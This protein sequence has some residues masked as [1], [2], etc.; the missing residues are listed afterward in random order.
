MNELDIDKIAQKVV[1]IIKKPKAG[2]GA[3][4]AYFQ[5][6]TSLTTID[7]TYQMYG[8]VGG[9]GTEEGRFT[10]SVLATYLFNSPVLNSP[11]TNNW[12]RAQQLSVYSTKPPSG[13]S[14]LY[15]VQSGSTYTFTG[16][17]ND[18]SVVSSLFNNITANG[19]INGSVGAPIAS[20]STINLDAATG[21]VVHITGTTNINNVTLAAGSSRTCIFDG[22]LQISSLENIVIQTGGIG[23]VTTI[24]NSTVVFTGDAAG[25][26]RAVYSSIQST[27]SGLP[28]C[29]NSPSL[30]SPNL[31]NA[32]GNSM[33]LLGNMFSL[34][35]IFPLQSTV[36]AGATTTLTNGS[37]YYQL[38]TGTLNQTYQ[39]PV[40]AGFLFQNT[41]FQFDNNSTGVLTVVDSASNPIAIVQ[42]GGTA[43]VRVTDITTSAGVWSVRLAAS[44]ATTSLAGIAELATDA[45]ALAGINSTNIVTPENLS[46]SGCLSSSKA[47][48]NV[49]GFSNAGVS[50]GAIDIATGATN[51]YNLLSAN[52][53][54]GVNLTLSRTFDVTVKLNVTS[55]VASSAT[56]TITGSDCTVGANGAPI[57][58]LLTNQP[59]FISAK[60]TTTTGTPVITVVASGVSG[61]VT[62]ANDS[63]ISIEE[64]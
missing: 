5:S 37:S 35:Q 38:L 25:V 63:Y 51:T 58:A 41:S 22:I 56:F 36:S 32:S 18:E 7:N 1:E 30:N 64:L 11:I 20:A 40:A 50:A 46:S 19:V 23:H 16:K 2:L 45:E 55:I 34:N 59:L 49:Y 60:V 15:V 10:P 21:N 53:T 57:N 6:R 47:W 14:D 42:A 26:V 31:N 27:G 54:T 61:T 17:N 43:V 52:S 3:T 8:F 4:T 28:V 39:L 62:I 9:A 24:A 29:Q 13:Y 48:A 33:S 12:I 44:Q